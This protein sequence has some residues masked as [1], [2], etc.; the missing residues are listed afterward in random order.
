MSK[1]YQ[2]LALA[3]SSAEVARIKLKFTDNNDIRKRKLLHH[4]IRN[5]LIKSIK[6]IDELCKPPRFAWSRLIVLGTT[7]L[8]SIYLAVYCLH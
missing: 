1:T 7:I 3:M 4:E 6:I 8:L 5:Q 2:K